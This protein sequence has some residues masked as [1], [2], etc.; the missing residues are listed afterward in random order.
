MTLRGRPKRERRRHPR[1][2][3]SFSA[4]LVVSGRLYSARVINLSMGGAL[5]DL[6]RLLPPPAIDA[7]QALLVDIRCR[8]G[9]G[10]LH[11]DARA[12]TWNPDV[13][14]V[15]LLSVQFGP[16]SDESAEILEELMFEAL[17]E[18]HGRVVG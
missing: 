13:D 4:I 8:G 16:M 9:V 12:V 1:A 5:L 17:Y 11:L 14:E 10:P 7:G 3:T 15:P 2:I 18:L 6:G